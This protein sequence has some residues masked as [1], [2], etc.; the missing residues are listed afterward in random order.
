[1]T[2]SNTVY[3]GHPSDDQLDQLRAELYEDPAIGNILRAHVDSCA[4]CQARTSIWRR[5]TAALD[6]MNA[7]GLAG[8][9]SAR[10]RQ[11]Q[12]GVPARRVMPRM[13][14]A[15]AAVLAA[16]AIGLGAVF[17]IAGPDRT[18]VVTADADDQSDIY[19]DLEFYLWLI[20]HE[21]DDGA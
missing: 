16:I 15:L 11:A 3:A 5:A 20:N 2:R 21:T 19:A 6:A 13:V 12:K 17:Y 7:P 14:R 1:M 9:L 4:A 8:A 10:R 18:P